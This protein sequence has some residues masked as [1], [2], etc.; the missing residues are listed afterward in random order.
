MLAW[1]A[2]RVYSTAGMFWAKTFDLEAERGGD[3]R[4]TA[5]LGVAGRRAGA[6]RRDDS[7]AA[8]R[9]GVS[10][11]GAVVALAP[12]TFGSGKL[13]LVGL[14]VLLVALWLAVDAYPAAREEMNRHAAHAR[15]S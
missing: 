9:A 2:T 10:G 13:K 8:G 6:V 4:N 5:Y 3:G 15:K 11:L 7:L 1:E 14:A 12:L